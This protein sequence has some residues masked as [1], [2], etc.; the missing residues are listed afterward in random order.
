M[1]TEGTVET[2][3]AHTGDAG[4]C[5]SRQFFGEVRFDISADAAEVVGQ[6]WAPDEF[7]PGEGDLE[8]GEAITIEGIGGVC[9]GGVS[10][11][12]ANVADQT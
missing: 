11:E 3:D 7:G 6:G 2:G 1:F 10:D 12:A 8:E 4:E 5:T 9:V